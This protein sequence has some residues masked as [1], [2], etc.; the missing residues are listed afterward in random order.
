MEK[1]KN[2]LIDYIKKFGDKYCCFEDLLPYLNILDS[3][4]FL[5]EFKTELNA[6]IKTVWKMKIYIFNYI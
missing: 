5:N 2:I 3:D 1:H 4:D 6:L